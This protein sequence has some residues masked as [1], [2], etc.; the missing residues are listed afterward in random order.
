MRCVRLLALPVLLP[1][2]FPSA[3]VAANL[4][5]KIRYDPP[6]FDHRTASQLEPNASC[7]RYS[8]ATSGG[9]GRHDTA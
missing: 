7:C 9:K 2:V 4:I 3:V 6:A 5:H 8:S 1:V